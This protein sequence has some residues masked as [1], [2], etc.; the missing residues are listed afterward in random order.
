MGYAYE[1][2]SMDTRK[3]HKPFDHHC[4][5]MGSGLNTYKWM[6]EKRQKNKDDKTCFG[7]CKSTGQVKYGRE[8]GGHGRDG[9]YDT[10]R[11]LILAGF[12]TTEIRKMTG[13]DTGKI[14]RVRYLMKKKD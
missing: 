3:E 6:C 14:S 13:M 11:R 1:G 2:P 9:S 5:E 10:I 12:T 8:K 4:P 7:G